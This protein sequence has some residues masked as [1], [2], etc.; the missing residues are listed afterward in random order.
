MFTGKLPRQWSALVARE[1]K[2]ESAA[3]IS[4]YAPFP[5]PTNETGGQGARGSYP[6]H[7]SRCDSIFGD[8][9]NRTMHDRFW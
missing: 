5:R 9:R 2:A 8:L 3:Y 1:K 4:S 7:W 6:F